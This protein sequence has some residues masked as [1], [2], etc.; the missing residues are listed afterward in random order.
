MLRPVE[1][2]PATS[3]AS[4]EGLI[5]QTQAIKI[6]HQNQLKQPPRTKK[7]DRV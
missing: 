4:L 6:P 1:K 5:D 2:T 3:D 7:T